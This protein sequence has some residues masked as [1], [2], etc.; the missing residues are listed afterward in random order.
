[1]TELDDHRADP[2]S[3]PGDEES[4]E[5][6][7]VQ[8]GTTRDTA[9]PGLEADGDPSELDL[10]LETRA[11]VN[12]PG[13]SHHAPTPH[14]GGMPAEAETD[15]A[16][17]HA[18]AA[19]AGADAPTA[20]AR[21]DV[22]AAGAGAD[23]PAAGAETDGNART[24]AG[25][26]KS[27]RANADAGAGAEADAGAEARTDAG[28]GAEP[29][30]G[31]DAGAD[32]HTNQLRPRLGAGSPDAAAQ[33]DT[34]PHPAPT[35]QIPFAEPDQEEPAASFRDV[36]RTAGSYA[37]GRLSALQVFLQGHRPVTI[38]TA[39]VFL[40]AV[41][42][43]VVFAARLADL[44]ATTAIEQDIRS[45]YAR[46]SYE[47]STYGSDDPLGLFEIRVISCER[48]G[49]PDE[50]VAQ[51][52]LS[53]A[54]SSLQ[55][56]EDVSLTYTRTDGTWTCTEAGTPENLVYTA[57][58]GI[59]KTKLVENVGP[60]LSK[61]EAS[62][63]DEGKDSTALSLPT[64]YADAD[65]AIT[66]ETFDAHEQDDHILLHLE[67]SS[68]FTSYECD[69]SARFVFRPGN[70]AWELSSASVDPQA[71]ELTFA[72]LVGTWEGSFREQSALEAKCFGAKSADM[73]IVI[74]AAEDGR[75][76]GTI[77]CLA[78]YHA[79]LSRDAEG[80]EDDVQLTDVP[81]S[82]TIDATSTGIAFDCTTPEDAKGALALRLEFGTQSDPSAARATVITSSS[83]E[84]A[85]LF[86]P[87]EREARFAD[88][89]TLTKR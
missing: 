65:V 74:D 71:K 51:A 11:I 73:R 35:A 57:T 2:Q 87:Y 53:Y 46:A 37:R 20:D 89:Y 82:G 72:P 56:S 61:A 7:P 76:T 19:D 15:A 22:P 86:I 67:H 23:A 84:S 85:F 49:D 27:A 40:V 58:T 63:A 32:G 64:L 5:L 54:S 38:A 70:G 17:A 29:D 79:D 39:L 8:D 41:L 1:M 80:S 43:I 45:H 6:A 55:L 77:S 26:D 59:D 42:V 47:P 52:A 50:C 21:A 14:D 18:P 44:P 30:A 36:T 16:G 83:Y 81:F 25:A 24:R 68:A 10:T 88:S 13:A 34:L 48:T 69:L 60:V 33:D 4:R 12:E 31:A 66:S 62:L 3:Q 78:H 28:A 75:V 9:R